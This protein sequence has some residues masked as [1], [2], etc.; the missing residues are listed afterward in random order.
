M[1]KKL[2]IIAAPGWMEPT[3]IEFLDRHRGELLVNQTILP[4]V[5][6]DY[7]W[8]HIMASEP[9]MVTAAKQLAE[10]GCD[11]IA[12][13]GPAFSYFM[14]G[15]PAG[16]RALG[17]RISRACGVPVILNGVAVL[18]ALEALNATC[19]ALASPYYNE[20]WKRWYHTFLTNAGYEVE[21]MQT[22]MDQGL[23]FKSQ[24]EVDARLWQFSVEEVTTS[25]RRTRQIV[26]KTQAI[27]ISGAGIRSLQWIE[28][29]QAE[30]PI[31]LVS[32]DHALYK[33]VCAACGLTPKAKCP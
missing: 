14:G 22:F 21:T 16:A 4:P 18:D 29:L 12:Q 31:P 11:L 26:K 6:F 5:G 33:A 2:G 10:S 23:F 15:S 28:A 24:D 1:T 8:N 30:N 3:M 27:L 13:V 32:A 9:H 7:S 25:V 20:T 17:E 19:V